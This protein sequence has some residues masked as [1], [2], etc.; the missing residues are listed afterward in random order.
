MVKLPCYL[1]ITTAVDWDVIPQTKQ[2]ADYCDCITDTDLL[3]TTAIV[4]D[5]YLN[6]CGK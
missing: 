2:N 3:N 5:D 1:L 4:Q 6:Y